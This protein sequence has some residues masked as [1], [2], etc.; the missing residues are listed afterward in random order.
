MAAIVTHAPI[1]DRSRIIGAYGPPDRTVRRRGRP[2]RRVLRDAPQIGADE[3]DV[4]VA[5][6]SDRAQSARGPPAHSHADRQERRIRSLA[7]L[8]QSWNGSPKRDP[9]RPVGRAHGRTRARRA[10]PTR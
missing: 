5:A 3:I 7:D 1:V 10:A 8:R 4:L 9:D 2:G 6:G